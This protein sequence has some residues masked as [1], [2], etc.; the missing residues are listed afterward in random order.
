MPSGWTPRGFLE[1]PSPF[2]GGIGGEGSFSRGHR[3]F[4]RSA[5][6]HSRRSSAGAGLPSGALAP[7]APRRHW[8]SA[9]SYTHLETDRQ[10]G[11]Y[12]NIGHFHDRISVLDFLLRFGGCQ[13]KAESNTTVIE[14]I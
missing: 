8:V 11:T 9:V 3:Q 6:P 12:L 14:F 1:P 7:R 13:D 5:G 10:P 4:S 2:G